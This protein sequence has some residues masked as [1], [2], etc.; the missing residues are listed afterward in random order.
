M[1]M[2]TLA[3]G[4]TKTFE[5]LLAHKETVFR[6]CLGYARNYSDA[7]DLAQESYLRAFRGINGLSNPASARDWLL[8][9]VRNACIDHG[10]RSRLGSFLPFLPEKDDIR[11]AD[12]NPAVETDERA[13]ALKKAVRKLPEKLKTVFIL[14][15]YGGLSYR[16]VA[17]SLGIKEG[18]VMSR[19]SRARAGL[20]RRI[21]ENA[22]G[23]S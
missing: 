1:A 4:R 5:G 8:A 12:P 3:G 7:E 15:T 2:E 18:T 9:I 20:E 22:S 13:R 6:I 21:K 16:E 11:R 14:Y 19:L 23:K 17:G 10:R